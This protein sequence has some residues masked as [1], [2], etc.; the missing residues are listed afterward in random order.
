MI[1][2]DKFND[3]VH[4]ILFNDVNPETFND[5][6]HVILFVAFVNIAPLNTAGNVFVPSVDVQSN[7]PDGFDTRNEFIVFC[8][9][10]I[11]LHYLQ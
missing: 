4:V 8:V 7:H 6:V 11:I 3:D 10:K 5:D 2:P 1:N 9:N